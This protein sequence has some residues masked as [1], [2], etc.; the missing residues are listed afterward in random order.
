MLTVF[1]EW[2][3]RIAQKDPSMEL[4]GK[5]FEDVITVQQADYTESSL[6]ARLAQ[7]R[8]A[9]NI[10]LIYREWFIADSQCQYCCNGN[11]GD[12]CQAVPWPDRAEKGFWLQQT[13]V[14][15]N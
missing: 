6:E 15:Y 5:M 7:E 9:R 4:A 8:Y 2:D 12:A 14:D 1:N 3:Y 13:L 10:G 11:I